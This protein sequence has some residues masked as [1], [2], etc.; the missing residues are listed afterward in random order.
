M[1]EVEKAIQSP[2]NDT[3]SI[4]PKHSISKSREPKKK[5]DDELETIPSEGSDD[6]SDDEFAFASTNLTREG[7]AKCMAD[8]GMEDV[9]SMHESRLLLRYFRYWSLDDL[10]K[11][12]SGLLKDVN[13]NLVELVNDNYMK[14]ITLGNSLDGCSDSA[15]D[16]KIE[17]LN[18]K[19][20]LQA[21]NSTIRSIR[22]E[23]YRQS[24]KI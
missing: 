10:S 6:S 15:N 3:L 4:S 8:L 17:V 24:F 22:L 21:E 14:F 7:I 23:C 13:T 16:V 19:Q 11:N 12:L 20:K 18:Y 1:D 5:L 9:E 2:S